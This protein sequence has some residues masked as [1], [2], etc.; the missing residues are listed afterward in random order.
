M[1]IFFDGEWFAYKS[2]G[3]DCIGIYPS[4]ALAKAKVLSY[5]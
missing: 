1:V 2:N 3:V 4:E 5:Y